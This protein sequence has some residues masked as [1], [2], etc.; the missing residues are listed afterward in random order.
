MI[1]ELNLANEKSG[2]FWLMNNI[3]KTCNSNNR[4]REDG[5]MDIRLLA[6]LVLGS[7]EWIVCNN[8]NK[9]YAR[10]EKQRY[11]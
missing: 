9:A 5:W 11:E 2:S 3:P 8:T 7:V 1:D 10:R 6:W 4:R